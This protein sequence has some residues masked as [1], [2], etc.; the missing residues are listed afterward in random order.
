M[1]TSENSRIVPDSRA[2][3]PPEIQ[4]A[5]DRYSVV[6]QR[7][8][9][10]LN[11]ISERN[12]PKPLPKLQT[13]H[14]ISAINKR[15]EMLLS[16]CWRLERL[17]RLDKNKATQLLPPHLRVLLETKSPHPTQPSG[18]RNDVNA[19]PLMGNG[20]RV[21]FQSAVRLQRADNH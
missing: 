21:G 17:A 15:V 2:E 3:M 5:L 16:Q 8:K 7:H 6:M 4:R 14:D 10:L 1:P 11:G 18:K 9:T 12:L 13:C 20:N 19:E